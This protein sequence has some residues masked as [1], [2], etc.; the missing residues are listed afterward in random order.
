MNDLSITLTVIA[1]IG[2]IFWTMREVAFTMPL[3]LD[4]KQVSGARDDDDAF[5]FP[6]APVFVA[7]GSP[8]FSS[9][10]INFLTACGIIKA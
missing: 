7:D 2:I 4:A 6:G 3:V 5:D 1:F 8:M 10:G 9:G